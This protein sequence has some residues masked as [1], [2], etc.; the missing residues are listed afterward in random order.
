MTT[1]TYYSITLVEPNQSNKHITVN[2][3]FETLATALHTATGGVTLAGDVSGAVATTTVAKF[4]GRA[5][6]ATAPT[7]GQ[8]IA[9]DNAGST[10]KPVTP[11]SGL[12]D[13]PSDGTSYL[14]K[15][16]AWVAAYSGYDVP[17]YIPDKPTSSMICARIVAVRSFTL[18]S[19]LTGSVASA[20]TAATASTVFTIY[21][22]ASSVG[23]IT[24]AAAGTSGTFAMASGQSFVSGDLLRVLA[25]ATA[26]T[27][28]ADISITFNGTRT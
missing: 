10:W 1:T 17:I 14:R 15:D 20:G 25:P 5:F 16:A 12:A 28:L 24:F 4:Q 21:K 22:N 26:D 19:G 11:S 18:P 27:T 3:G 9:W 2:E 8:V 6:A 7:N 23:T 13:A